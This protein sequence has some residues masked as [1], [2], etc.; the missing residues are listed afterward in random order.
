MNIMKFK[1][2]ISSLNKI[3]FGISILVNVFLCIYIF[4]AINRNQ[5]HIYFSSDNLYLP[6]IYRDLFINHNSLAGWHLNGAPNFF[7]DMFLYFTIRSFFHSFIPAA[8]TY[9][10]VQLMILLTLLSI[11]YRQFFPKI[12]YMHLGIGVLLMSLFL[13]ETLIDHD[14]I[15]TFYILSISYHLGA[16]IMALLALILTIRFFRKG[17][18][19]GLLTL[20]L[21]SCVAIMNDRLFMSMYSIPL[22]VLAV[23]LFKKDDFHSRL[24]KLLVTVLLSVGTGMLFFYL[25]SYHSPV[26]IIDLGWKVFQFDNILTSLKVLLGQHRDYLSRLDIRGVIDVLFLVSLVLHVVLLVKKL[27]RYFRGEFYRINEL[28]YLLLFVAVTLVVLFMP[29]INGSYLAPSLMRYNVYSLF[30]GVFSFS[31]LAMKFEEKFR[32]GLK[33]IWLTAG[34]LGLSSIVLITGEFLK[35]DV[36][37]GLSGFMHYYPGE[38]ACLDSLA[39]E[40]HLKNGVATYWKAKYITMFSK[41]DLR[42]FT[43]FESLAPWYHVM[44]ENWYY[45][46]DGSH[47]TPRPFNFVIMDNISPE[48]VGRYLGTPK[49]RLHC[50]D[51][52]ILVF[53]AFYYDRKTR[54]PYSPENR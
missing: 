45:Y 50:G 10:L 38:V 30:F 39:R 32:N 54:R 6:S 22:M 41:E 44:N 35:N 7:P 18:W 49:E 19:P 24:W 17:K 27:R 28:I 2:S 12:G 21:L 3:F 40:Y 29:V 51:D 23:L 48:S 1:H 53:P 43:A 47:H 13:V 26:N 52:E 20:F 25:L 15:Y 11:L 36:K 14:F 46:E 5:V 16:F 37:T 31:Y 4:S 34:L 9:S 8:F 42:I 33:V